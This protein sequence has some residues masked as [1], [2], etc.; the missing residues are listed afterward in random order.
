MVSNG[1]KVGKNWL[2]QRKLWYG[3]GLFLPGW[4]GIS[5]LKPL[6]YR[7]SHTNGSHNSDTY[8]EIFQFSKKIFL[9]H[10]PNFQLCWKGI[11]KF[12]LNTPDI[13]QK[14][15]HFQDIFTFFL[16]FFEWHPFVS[17]F[18]ERRPFCFGQTRPGVLFAIFGNN[19]NF[20]NRTWLSNKVRGLDVKICPE[21][22]KSGSTW[23]GSF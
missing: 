12:D 10:N 8:F 22:D 13:F 16:H 11:S 15:L 2:I 9:T 6:F 20:F 23:I 21:P 5:T 1:P 4:E 19:Y 3:K 17:T 7:K 18:S 14:T